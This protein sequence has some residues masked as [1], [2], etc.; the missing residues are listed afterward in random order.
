MV[1]EY[2]STHTQLSEA[3]SD[4]DKVTEILKDV[5]YKNRVQREAEAE[6]QEI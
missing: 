3:L 1:N 6:A 2:N 4:Q 5:N